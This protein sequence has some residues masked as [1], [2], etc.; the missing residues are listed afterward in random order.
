MKT[1]KNTAILLRTEKPPL[2]KVKKKVGNHA[3]KKVIFELIIYYWI[4]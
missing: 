4:L 2:I 1:L 3:Q